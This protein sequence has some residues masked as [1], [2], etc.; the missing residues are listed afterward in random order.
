MEYALSYA[1]YNYKKI[2][3]NKNLDAPNVGIIRK[4]EGLDS[5]RGFVAVHIAMV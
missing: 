5:E 2:E 1:L 4:F 3:I